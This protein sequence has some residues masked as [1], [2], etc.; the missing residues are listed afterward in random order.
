MSNVMAME[1][2]VSS[3]D[4]GGKIDGLLLLLLL[5][6]Y[7]TH[8][9]CTFMMSVRS[10]MLHHCLGVSCHAVSFPAQSSSERWISMSI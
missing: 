4:G 5:P 7:L 1:M 8:T 10:A 9:F 6:S 2:C 3:S